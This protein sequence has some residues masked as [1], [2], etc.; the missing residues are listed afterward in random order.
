MKITKLLISIIIMLY[1]TFAYSQETN[2][3]DAK[4]KLK[5]NNNYKIDKDILKYV[6]NIE[7]EAL[8]S[9]YEA[10]EYPNPAYENGIEGQ[11]IAKIVVSRGDL[12]IYCKIESASDPS[13]G[14]AVAK[15]FYKK[16]LIIYKSLETDEKIEFY[17]PF[18]FKTNKS[19]FMEELKK[20]SFIK[21][22]KN[23]MQKPMKLM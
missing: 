4:G 10:I 15:A 21:I 8:Q 18:E 3:Y 22:E 5:I 20:N 6:G 1:G 2:L 12:S 19:F 7:N 11:V 17:V 16:S 9:V 13:L 23:F 14:K